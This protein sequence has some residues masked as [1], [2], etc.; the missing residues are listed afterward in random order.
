MSNKAS[1]LNENNFYEK[2]IFIQSF[3]KFRN[4]FYFYSR[5]LVNFDYF[6]TFTRLKG[7]YIKYIK[8]LRYLN[9]SL[10]LKHMLYRSKGHCIYS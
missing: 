7:N 3:N 2:I 9:W 1:H 10:E 5:I 4:I 6:I 8:R